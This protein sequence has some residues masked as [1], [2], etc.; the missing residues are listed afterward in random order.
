MC[1]SVVSA[2]C[3]YGCSYHRVCVRALLCVWLCIGIYLCGMHVCIYVSYISCVYLYVRA[4]ACVRVCVCVCV[5]VARVCGVCMY[6]CMAVWR[7]C[8]CLVGFDVLGLEQ[9]VDCFAV[10]MCTGA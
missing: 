9:T 10:Y 1:C 6:F 3:M 7:V 2:A 8:V 5:C 4:C